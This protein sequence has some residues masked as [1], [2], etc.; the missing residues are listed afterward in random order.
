MR[1][2][3]PLAVVAALSSAVTAAVIVFPALAEDEPVARAAP[4]RRD[5]PF[6]DVFRRFAVCMRDQGFDFGAD[7]TLRVEPDGVTVNGKKVDADAF[8][9]AERACGGPP[10]R[11][12]ERP[13]PPRLGD[14]PGRRELEERRDAF[15]EDVARRLGVTGDRLKEALREAALARIAALERSGVIEGAHADALRELARSGGLPFLGGPLLRRGPQMILPPRHGG[16]GEP[17]R[18]VPPA[19]EDAT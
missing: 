3:V 11:G 4:D 13:L 10:F 7:T 17:E 18:I 1:R 15:L 19:L 5:R 9:R 12:L 8:R 2:L 16:R 14:L 6:E